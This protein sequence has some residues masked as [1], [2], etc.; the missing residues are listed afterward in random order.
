MMNGDLTMSQK[1]ADRLSIINQVISKKITARESSELL[2]LSERQVF[3]ILSRVRDE[4]SKGVIHKLRGKKSNRGYTEGLKKEVIRI[5]KT[6]YVDYGPTLFSEELLKNHNIAVDHDTVRRWMRENFIPTSERKKRPHRRRR[7]RRSALG[8]MIQFDGSHHDW[9]EGRGDKCCLYVCVDDSTGKV[10][11]RFGKTENTADAMLTI[12]EYVKHNGI[13]RSIYLDRFSAYY[14]K[15]KLTDFSRA[16]REMEVEVIYA[17]SPQAKG[18]VENRNRTLQDRLVKAM[19]QR[20]ISTIADANE[21]LRNEFTEE[22]NSKFTVN[23]EAPDVHKSTARYLLE[24]IFCYK[25]T[26]QVRNDYTINLAGGY[27]QLLKGESPLPKPRQ[28]VTL[29]KHLSGELFIYF[30]NQKLRYEMLTG[31]KAKQPYKYRKLP[32]DHPWRRMNNQMPGSKKLTL[33]SS[34]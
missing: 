27:V 6:Q 1:E 2:K 3:R 8:E 25:T 12:W 15:G 28:D 26:R 11:L 9:F 29:H 30:N 31:K 7:E 32:S 17:K 18:R 23:L 19:R 34:T 13:P 24:E 16:M 14:A 20:G 10:H 21:Y 5:Y 22:F 33:S 4:G